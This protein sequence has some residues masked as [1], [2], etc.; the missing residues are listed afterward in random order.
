MY[1]RQEQYDSDYNF[2]STADGN[3]VFYQSFTPRSEVYLNSVSFLMKRSSAVTGNISFTV[4]ISDTVNN[5]DQGAALETS[6]TYNASNLTTSYQLVTFTFAGT[7]LLTKDSRYVF[8]CDNA[9][10]ANDIIVAFSSQNDYA[11]GILQYTLDPMSG[12][13]P[14]Y[15]SVTAT[16]NGADFY[17]VVEFTGSDNT[18]A[19]KIIKR[20][21][22]NVFRK[23][24]IKRRDATTGQFEASWVEITKDVK[25]WGSVNVNTDVDRVGRISFSGTNLV[26]QNIEGRYN[27]NSNTYSLWYG[28]SSQQRS[29]LKI[30]CAFYDQYQSSGVWVNEIIPAEPTIFVGIVSGAIRV[31]DENE[32]TLPVKP[33]NQVF[34]D[35]LVTDLTGFTAAGPGTTGTAANFIQMLRDQT[36][37]GSYLF[38]PFFNDTTSY[39]QIT[40][41]SSLTYPALTGTAD[42]LRD[43]TVWDVIEKLAEAE[44]YLPYIT[45]TGVFKWIPKTEGSTISYEFNG[46]GVVP[47]TEY[48]HTI[49]KIE[50]Y[51]EKISDYYNRV[52]V[53]YLSAGAS[54]YVATQ[55]TFAISGSNDVWN[56]GRRSYFVDNDFI[57]SSS[58]AASIA[59]TLLTELSS[60]TPEINFS[61]SLITHI[62]LLDKV[63]ISYDASDFTSIN[64]YWDAADW[65][66]FFTWDAG[67]GD[68][69]VLTEQP[70]KIISININL[71]TLETR[72]VAR[73]L[74]S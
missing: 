3:Y 62:N 71:D 72:F 69:I 34:R 64:G 17:F 60:L 4:H 29:L 16:Y 15:D 50:A 61:T 11:D 13:E 49:K 1:I 44:N 53:S 36:V 37:G 31:S 58:N 27:P 74:D 51:G 10:T 14:Y 68:A 20:N 32:I 9:H 73:Q 47:N 57:G 21:H 33:L 25:K 55:S 22:S 42:N 12:Y 65:D 6:S 59:N 45:R 52:S 41:T 18:N 43:M 26:M 56:L 24:Y 66:D 5:D 40:Q 38:R 2:K 7:T 70:F 23:A 67:R 63:Y 19:I 46:L 28:Y 35:Y 8:K 48:G 39:W 54:A 30:E